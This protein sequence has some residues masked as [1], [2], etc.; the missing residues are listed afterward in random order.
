MNNENGRGRNPN[1]VGAAWL[2][3][4]KNGDDYISIVLNPEA[5]QGLDL[6]NCFIDMYVNTKKSKPNQPDY[7]IVAKP[8]QQ[9]AA[10]PQAVPQRQQSAFPKPRNFA[11]QSSG[12][13]P[14][15]TGE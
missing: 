4:T 7:R 11:P 1:E 2:K 8:K 15:D 5:T 14:E 13:D 3:Q 12:W 10:R 6:P 9:Q